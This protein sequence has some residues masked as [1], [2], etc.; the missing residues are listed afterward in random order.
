MELLDIYK[1]A[2]ESENFLKVLF[3]HRRLQV[4]LSHIKAG[5]ESGEEVW[6]ADAAIL[7]LYGQGHAVVGGEERSVK[8]GDLFYVPSETSCNI[9]NLGAEPVKLMLMFG[10]KVFKEGTV[11]GTKISEIMDPYKTRPSN[12]IL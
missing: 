12:S 7:V 11:E 10:A 4:A 3:T 5:E 2:A 1:S 6:V 8:T 9:I